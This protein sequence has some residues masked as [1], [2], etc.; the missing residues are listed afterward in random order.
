MMCALLN[1]CITAWCHYPS[2]SPSVTPTPSVTPSI[3]PS[4]SPTPSITPSRT[5]SPSVTPSP[6]LVPAVFD[7]DHCEGNRNRKAFSCL[8]D[9]ERKSYVNVFKA[10][11]KD[12]TLSDLTSTFDNN[13]W[14]ATGGVKFLPWARTIL[15]RFENA[16]RQVNGDFFV[17]YWD[18]TATAKDIAA[19]KIW[20][21]KNGFG[22]GKPGKCFKKGAWARFRVDYPKKHC[23]RRDFKKGSPVDGIDAMRN[24]IANAETFQEFSDTAEYVWH[25]VRETV[26]GEFATRT[27]A[28][29][30]LFFPLLATF[31]HIWFMWQTSHPDA[32]FG[33]EHRDHEITADDGLD[34]FGGIKISEILSTECIEYTTS[35]MTGE[36]SDT[37]LAP[38]SEDY[39]RFNQLPVNRM[40]RTEGTVSAILYGEEDEASPSPDN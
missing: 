23:I 12:G 29:D 10:L 17:P 13:V 32:E 4:S 11:S 39:M 1:T 26:G 20:T 18:F 33:G 28:N 15:R 9:Q 40:W 31:D 34:A 22:R 21:M 16:G 27:G 5:P 30:P 8:S 35:C 6:S 2:P 25:R 37:L 38:L 36:D 24:L 19:S 14:E 3:T 7:I